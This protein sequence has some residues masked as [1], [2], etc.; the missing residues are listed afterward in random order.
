MWRVSKG[1]HTL[2]IL[3]TLSPLPRDFVWQSRDVEAVIAN[4]QE[5][6]GVGRA[7]AKIGLGAMIKMATLAPAALRTQ[8]NEDGKPLNSVVEPALFA[9]W[10]SARDQYAKSV[11]GLDKLRPVYA[12]QQLYWSAVDTVGLT[13]SDVVAP[14]VRAAATRAGLTISDTGFHYDL[15]IDRKPMKKNID[16]VNNFSGGDIACFAATL[17]N[18][19]HDLAA[20]KLRA[21][22]WAIG[23]VG[24]LRG[25][26]KA[27][28]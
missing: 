7:N 5:V 27:D 28:F 10:T 19:E 17:D 11:K 6:L 16:G 3:G 23:D 22:A 24:A 26:T 8:H 20:M 21:N 13:R 25:L 1:S 12:S 18:L 9:R 14:V 4:S 2:W 15:S